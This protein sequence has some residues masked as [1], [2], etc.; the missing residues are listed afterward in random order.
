[1]IVQEAPRT[2]G[3]GA[4]LAA[5]IAE[6]ALFRLRAPVERVTGYDVAYPYWRVEDVYLPSASRVASALR[7]TL[8]Y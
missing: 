5:I 8:E 1:V 4:E 3:F 2:A 7:R 6:K